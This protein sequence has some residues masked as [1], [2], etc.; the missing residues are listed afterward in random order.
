MIRNAISAL[1]SL[2]LVTGAAFGALKLAQSRDKPA[3]SA[4]AERTTL[5]EAATAEAARATV[6]VVG[7]GTVR[8]AE[9]VQLRSELS[10]K[11][12]SLHPQLV[13]GG[14]VP[15]GETLI[16]L[17]K[18][19]FELRAGELRSSVTQARS[20]L[21]VEQ[22]RQR[23]AEREWDL[24]GEDSA[25]SAGKELALRKPQVK[26]ARAGVSG[27][28]ASLGRAELDLERTTLL[29]PFSA[30]VIDENVGPGQ[31]LTAQSTLATLIK[32]DIFL[33]EVSVPVSR[34]SRLSIPGVAGA[35]EGARATVRLDLGDTRALEREGRVVRL[36]GAL[37][38]AG[39]MARVLVE[40]RDPLALLPENA[41]SLP[42]LL[43][44]Y[45]KVEIEGR[46][47]EDVVPLPRTALRDGRYVWVIDEALRLEVRE[48]RIA[49][50]EKERV[51]L[52]EGLRPGERYVTTAIGT[53]IEGMRL[54]V[55][56]GDEERAD[57]A[58]AE[59]RA[60]EVL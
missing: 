27:A 51:L 22:G 54:A 1:L 24:L 18:R 37:D 53:A 40:V 58:N 11:V 17:D 59:G 50:R 49:W 60:P 35:A 25:G 32:T 20:N 14:L 55:S 29:A 34:L 16:Q 33:V 13:A 19:P 26:S 41:G 48:V 30:L 47:L 21:K 56:G 36:L 2:L 43:G 38:Q 52:S 4:P 6:S 45:V 5:V 10:G 57:H 28:R 31:V 15:E 9:T 46:P 8:A 23:T 44:S 12:E 39:R 42:L 3:P 7:H